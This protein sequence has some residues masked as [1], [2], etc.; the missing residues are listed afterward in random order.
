MKTGLGEETKSFRE[1]MDLSRKMLEYTRAK[2]A[3]PEGER[4]WIDNQ[5][6]FSENEER[7][8]TYILAG[9]YA[10]IIK[11][12]S[13]YF[14]RQQIKIIFFDDLKNKQEETL[15][16]IYRFLNV[17]DTFNIKHKETVNYQIDRT[18]NKI[19]YTLLGRKGGRFLI[20]LMPKFIKDRLRKKLKAKQLP[21]LNGEERRY[22][23]KMFEDDVAELEKV[24]D[25]DL[26]HWNPFITEKINEKSKVV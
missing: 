15:A 8:R 4:Y 26:S 6:N 7:P 5:K 12:Y 22:Y 13:Q 24:V 9:E 3:S 18:A 20:Q 1:S 17:D 23:W 14:D 19:A 10:K 16:D 11:L 2:L 21:E 25:K